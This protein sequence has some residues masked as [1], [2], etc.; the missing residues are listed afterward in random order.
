MEITVSQLI[1]ELQQYDGNLKVDFQGLDYYR[2]KQRSPTVVQVEF[3]Q[4]VDYDP[5]EQTWSAYNP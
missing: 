5:D 2:L 3:G 1:S 4:I